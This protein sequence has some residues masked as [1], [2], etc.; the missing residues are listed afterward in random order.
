ME[1]SFFL[2]RFIYFFIKDVFKEY[3]GKTKVIYLFIHEIFLSSD[4]HVKIVILA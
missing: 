2:L 1:I 3:S 4:H